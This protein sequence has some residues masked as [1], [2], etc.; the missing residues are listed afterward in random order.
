MLGCAAIR[1]AVSACL[2]LMIVGSLLTAQTNTSTLA[3]DSFSG[4]SGPLQ[5]WNG[6]S[7][8]S[9]GWEIQNGS[10]TIPG[11][12]LTAINQLGWAGSQTGSYAVG[13]SNWQSAGR[14]FDSSTTGAFSSFVSNGLIGKSG[15]TLYLSVLM[16]KDL[17]T[18]DEMSLTL[19]PGA[20]PAWFVKTPLVSF[21]HFGNASNTGGVRYWSL[22]FSGS[23]KQ[24][25][26]PVVVGQTALLVLR[27]DFAATSKMSL[28]VNPPASGLPP[29]PDA[30]ATTTTSLAF[31][32]LAWYPGPSPGESSLDEIRVAPSWTGFGGGTTAPPPAP[33]NLTAAAGNGQVSLAWTASAGATSYQVYQSANGS[34]TLLATVTS[35]AFL[36][37]GLTN[38]VSYS[39]YVVA[40]AGSVASSPSATVTAT[41]SVA[42][43]T[44]KPGLGTNLTQVTDYGRELPFVDVFKTARPWISQTQGGAW[45]QGPA[46]QLDSNGWPLSFQTGQYV[47]TIMLDNALEDQAHYPS[48]QYTLLYDG[49]GTIQFDLQ[50]A[51]IVSQTPGRMV[52]NVPPG[53]NGVFLMVTATNP[54]N[55]LRNI[56]FIMPGYESTYATQPFNPVFVQKLSGYRVLRFMEWLLTNG[57]TVQNWSDR[58]LPSDYTYCLRGVPLEVIV[59]LA[60]T[61]GLTP[62]LNIPAQASDDYVSH[63]VSLVSQQLSPSLKFYLEYSN[64]TWNGSFSQ[65]AWIQNQGLAMGFSTDR[66]L[67]GFFYTSY[68]SAA[69]FRL[70]AAALASPSQIIRV[71]PAQAVNSWL[72]DQMLNFQNTFANADVLAIAPYFNCDDTAS[73]GFG[74]LGDPATASQ[75]DAMTV[76]Q[77]VNIE[78]AHVNG[79]SFSA[80]KSSAA[81]A[82]KYGLRLVA[83]EG[84][85]SLVG[86]NGAEND[87]T[88]TTLF[89]AANRS[90]RMTTVY[91][92]YLNNWVTAGGD[93]FVHYSD[94]TAFTRYGSWGSL[95][96]QDQDPATAPK[97][98]A[99]V[100]FAASH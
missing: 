83:Y 70:A 94:V 99:L 4:A 82:S 51:S 43:P 86:F 34:G 90:P 62:W 57:S 11:Y 33:T 50:S 44:P 37:S 6:G 5:G 30:S 24:T 100:S 19:H 8:W 56:R 92:Q 17:S 96:Y 40:L 60:N 39:F 13:G 84:G 88:M 63:F 65:S 31:H 67:A 12:N 45:G 55:H 78:L 53:Q 28:Y 36:A 32:S 73:G 98:Q 59:Q 3:A 25:K 71:I 22:K 7:G 2:S 41:P 91:A 52:V 42:G 68:R 35:P 75:V 46:L 64:E 95:E 27:I 18:D 29:T 81:V 69:I 85:Q 26:I 61:T 58:A 66:T 80:M 38:F 89:K 21:G 97:Y 20:G 16:R 47:E 72:S 9:N 15:T 10:T 54:A 74:M 48:G 14:T 93:M 77:I 1:S 23:V 87:G 49:E 79:C 76:D